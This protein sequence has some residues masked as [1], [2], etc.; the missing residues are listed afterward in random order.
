MRKTINPQPNL[1]EPWL[2][3]EHARELETISSL[4]D[5][6]P[7]LNELVLQDLRSVTPPAGS[8]VGRGGMS[9]EQV[10]RALLVKQLN[11]FTYR[12]LAFHLADSRSYRT[13]CQLGII[14]P[15]P[16]K[17]TLAAN[18]KAVKF[19]TL[20]Q[21][22]RELVSVAE[23]AGIEKGRKVRVDCTVVESNIHPPTDS[24]LLYDCVRVLTR[25]MCRARELLGTVVVFGNRTRRAKRRAPRQVAYDGAFS[26]KANLE[27]I[28]GKGVEDVAFT[29]AHFAVTDMVKS[30]WVYQRLRRFRC[31][32]EGVIS[33]LKRVFGLDRCTWHSLPSFKSYVWSS[34]IT[35]NLLMMARHLLR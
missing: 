2:E 29:K 26:S 23:D 10:L 35:C 9:A 6:H 24:E 22:N 33:F 20:E 11:Q 4:L 12:E 25:V 14:E 19:E 31:G 15:T 34:I 32:I 5:A 27:A 7:K 3:L 16:S 30:S 28:K 21:I 18:I 8:D 1:R 13:F 17:S